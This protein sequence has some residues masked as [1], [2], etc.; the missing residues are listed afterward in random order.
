MIT[1]AP[2]HLWLVGILAVLWNSVGVV[3]YVMTQLQNAAYMS[4]FTQVQL[5]YFYSQPMWV[6][7]SWGI[8]VWSSLIGSILLLMRKKISVGVFLLSIVGV[9]VTS[10]YSYGLS[11]GYEIMGGLFALIFSIMIFVIA[12]ALYFYAKSMTNKGV[13]T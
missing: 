3:D 8:A 10:V 2:W 5:D 4:A 7:I 6:T 1:K 11:N 12:V 9:V 13:L